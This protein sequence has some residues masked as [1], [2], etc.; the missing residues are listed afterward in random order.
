MEMPRKFWMLQ[1][2][3]GEAQV[4]FSVTHGSCRAPKIISAI[5]A[6][7]RK[8]DSKQDSWCPDVKKD[9]MA[10][11][12][13]LE[14]NREYISNLINMKSALTNFLKV[15]NAVT[16]TKLLSWLPEKEIW[17]PTQVSQNFASCMKGKIPWSSSC[18][19]WA[20][21]PEQRKMKPG[22]MAFC[23]SFHI[24][25]HEPPLASTALDV[26]MWNSWTADWE[27]RSKAGL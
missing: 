27:R 18:I 25:T 3:R 13:K 17:S 1:F 16:D 23:W 24:S 10:T 2:P 21:K 14:T 8:W 15:L 20:L 9:Q 4:T 12:L 6:L 26:L 22:S 11:F 7:I 5:A 19:R